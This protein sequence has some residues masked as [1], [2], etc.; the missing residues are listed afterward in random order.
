M[1]GGQ[2][3]TGKQV[4]DWRDKG[5]GHKTKEVR[6]HNKEFEGIGPVDNADPRSNG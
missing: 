4:V 6:K 3:Q 1:R 2:V 5:E